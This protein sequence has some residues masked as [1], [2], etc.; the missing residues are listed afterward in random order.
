YGTFK[1]AYT[2]G[3]YGIDDGGCVRVARRGGMKPQTVDPKFPGYTTVTSTRDVRLVSGS[4]PITQTV[5]KDIELFGSKRGDLRASHIR[6]F[7]SAF[8]VDIK[9]GSLY[10]GDK[11]VF[12]FGDTSQGSPG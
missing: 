4:L 6:P 7:W 9:D 12:T 1:I 10:E 3:K 8:Q 11:L 2:V 5:S